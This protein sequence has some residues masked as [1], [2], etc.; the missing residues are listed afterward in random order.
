MFLNLKIKSLCN[1]KWFR[2]TSRIVIVIFLTRIFFILFFL[3]SY[4]EGFPE[5]RLCRN[6][7]FYFSLFICCSFKSG[8]FSFPFQSWV[9]I[10]LNLASFFSETRSWPL[11][12]MLEVHYLW[13]KVFSDNLC[14]WEGNIF[15]ERN[16]FLYWL[17]RPEFWVSFQQMEMQNQ[18]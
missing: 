10:F 3:L 6:F 11:A 12:R 7:C 2:P 1:L 18:K 14:L 9:Q 8:L 4:M 13:I 16:V 17:Q 15:W 5:C